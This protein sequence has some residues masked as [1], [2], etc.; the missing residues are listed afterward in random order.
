MV[1]TEGTGDGCNSSWF[2]V[3]DT[4]MDRPHREPMEPFPRATIPRLAQ[5]SVS[6]GLESRGGRIY[7]YRKIWNRG[8]VKSEYVGGGVLA[9]LAARL[10]QEDREERDAR[11]ANERDRWD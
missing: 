4:S 8:R 2:P 9:I 5:G 10:D 1:P 3:P 7:F 6:M 11:K